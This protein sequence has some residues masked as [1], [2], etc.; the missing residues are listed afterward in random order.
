MWGVQTAPLISG[1]NMYYKDTRAGADLAQGQGRNS[2][3]A[4]GQGGGLGGKPGCPRG[5][6]PDLD[7]NK[8]R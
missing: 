8:G 7:A 5:G 6:G 2:R 1:V 4:S 3:P